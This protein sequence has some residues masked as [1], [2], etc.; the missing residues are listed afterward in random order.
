MSTLT[1]TRLPVAD[2]PPYKDKTGDDTAA[3]A[4]ALQA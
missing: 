4:K 3:I 2:L 1:K